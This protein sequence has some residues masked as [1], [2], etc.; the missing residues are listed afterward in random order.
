M[1][2]VWKCRCEKV[3]RVL[4]D[5]RINLS[6]KAGWYW[7]CFELCQDH[8]VRQRKINIASNFVGTVLLLQLNYLL[9]GGQ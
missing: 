2:L 9:I 7:S 1:T 6:T 5:L 8:T 4:I 3:G